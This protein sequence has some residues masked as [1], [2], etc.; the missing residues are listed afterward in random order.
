MT[1]LDTAVRTSVPASTAEERAARL[2]SAGAAW[3]ERIAADASAAQLTYRVRGT[4]EGSVASR[5]TAGRHEFVVD[6]P[7]ALAGDDV[8]AS[9][10]EYALGALIS[11]QIVV[12]RLYAQALGI[13]VDDIE[14]LAEGDLDAQ[15]LFGI[16][17]TVRP[18]FGAVRLDIRI[19]G[20]ESEE[21]YQQLRTAVDEHCPVLD[22]F[23]NATP[24]SVA[25]SKA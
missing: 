2:D 13:R 22:L 25:V 16:D 5:I 11:C 9:P 23:A 3:G 8:A 24:V 7:G 12:Y 15:K 14:I 17:E 19:T 20:P 21:R 4:G 6:E 10:V 18:G 1:I